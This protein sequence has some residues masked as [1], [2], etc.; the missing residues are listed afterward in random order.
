MIKN[1]DRIVFTT[2]EWNSFSS[3]P[4]S[5][6]IKVEANE[7]IWVPITLVSDNIDIDSNNMTLVD[8][9]YKFETDVSIEVDPIY[10]DSTVVW[11]SDHLYKYNHSTDTYDEVNNPENIEKIIFRFER[12][13]NPGQYVDHLIIYNGTEFVHADD[14]DIEFIIDLIS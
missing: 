1:N 8:G 5:F 13:M 12:P 7:G 6:K 2:E 4:I 11:G 14:L 3:T 10:G 9:D